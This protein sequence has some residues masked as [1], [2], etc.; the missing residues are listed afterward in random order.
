MAEQILK[1]E[2]S[3]LMQKSYID[4]SMSVI[5]ARAVP[6]IR[7]GLKPVQRRVLYAMEQLGLNYDKPHRKSARIVGDAMGKYHPHGDSSIYETLVVMEQDFKKGMA[8]VDGHGNFGSIEGDGAAAMRYTEA[9][10]KKFTQKVYLADLDKDVVNF[11]PNFD[12]TEKEPEV[13]PVRVPNILINGSEGIAVGMTTSIPT[14]NL[15]EVINAVEAYMDNT[16][17]TTG[18]LMQYLPGPDFPTGGIVINQDELLDIYETGVGKIKLRGKVVFEPAA[19]KSDRDKLVITEIPYTMIGANIGKFISDVVD[20]VESK[21]TADIYDISNE[22]SKE[23]IRIVLELKKGADPEK[24]KN[25]LYKK[26]KLEDTFGVNMLA[27]VDG[28]PETLGLK[29]IIEHHVNFQIELATRKYTTLLNKE[30]ENREIK[31]GLIKACDIIDLIIE[32]LRGS[33]SLKQAKACLINGDTTDIKFKSEAS[34]KAASKLCF[35]DR[36]ATAI[37]ELRLSKLIGLEILA[38][39]KEYE[40]C[41]KRIAEYEDIL[42]NRKTMVKTIKKDLE[43]IKKEYGYDRRT[44]IENGA[45]AVYEEEKIAEQEVVFL[46]DRFGYARTIDVST[47]ERNIDAVLTENKYAFKCMNTDRICIFTDTGNLHQVKVMDL[48]Y[49]KLRDKGTPIDNLCNYNSSVENMIF[50]CD[51]NSLKNTTL[52]F[53]TKFGMAKL[54]DSSE[55]DVMKKTVLG[56]KLNEGDLVVS[57]DRVRI[58]KEVYSRF[59]LDGDTVEEEVI[60]SNQIIVLKTAQGTFLKFPLSDIPEKKKGAVGVRAIKLADKDYID[61]VYVISDDID[62]TIEYKGK[63]IETRKLKLAHRDTKGTKVRV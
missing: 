45:V 8:L 60:E 6:D 29:K 35:T 46:M 39:N 34:K 27:I 12:E 9:K 50:L 15:V 23:G 21:K 44:V 18:E 61:E 37:L 56:T 42:G 5:T 52:L 51:S 32:I 47:Y 40:E 53:T 25:M 17:I 10:L 31:E 3:E 11:V 2:Y 26:T 43:S 49:G 14:H 13:L 4:Y 20:L 48:P 63:Q 57:I 58:T 28:R 22:S 41:L 1:T 38:L 24:L 19:K 16:N 36:Q 7:D 54:V 59:T 33:R 62:I 55:F 30:L